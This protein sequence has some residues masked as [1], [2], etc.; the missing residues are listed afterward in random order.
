MS[1]TKP[2]KA[3]LKQIC[4]FIYILL[5]FCRCQAGEEI[6]TQQSPETRLSA[7]TLWHANFPVDKV[8]K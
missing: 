5:L 1:E 3:T 4:I 8:L 2:F 6:S 7:C